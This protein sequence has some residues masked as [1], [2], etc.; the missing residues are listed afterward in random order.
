MAVLTC[1]YSLTK[2]P[3][4]SVVTRSYDLVCPA[5][6]AMRGHAEIRNAPT[7]YD[8]MVLMTM[9]VEPNKPE[10]QVKFT[11]AGSRVG[12]CAAK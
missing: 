11:F 5:P 6:N 3:A 9:K 12:D 10:R 2:I 4:V 1:P 8:G 7:S